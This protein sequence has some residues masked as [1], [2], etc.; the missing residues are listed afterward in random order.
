MLIPVVS[1]VPTTDPGCSAATRG[2]IAMIVYCSADN[3]IY[4]FRSGIWRAA[5]LA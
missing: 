4:V 5:T 1:S 2:D 3:K